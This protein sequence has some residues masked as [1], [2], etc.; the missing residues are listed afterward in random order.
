LTG[1]E[2]I[3]APIVIS[4]ADPRVCLRLLGADADAEWRRQIEAIPML[5]CTMKVSVALSELPNFA[6]RPGTNQDHH[7]G[8]INTPLSKSEWKAGYAAA[9]AGNLPDKLWTEL[10]FQ[11]AMDDSV[12]P[13]G[14]HVMSVFAQYVP[15][16]L[17][18]GGW[19]RRREEAGDLA[20]ASIARYCTNLPGAI[21]HREVMGPPDIERKVGLTG[22]HIFQGECLP[23][24]M[25]D[26][27]PAYRTPMSGVYLCGAGVHPGGSVIG[28]NGR[29]AAMAVLDD[30]GKARPVT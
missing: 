8:Q 12:A 30:M 20:I 24:Y 27:R 10:Y 11:S 26:R 4:N 1:G 19:E 13:P 9:R 3:A 16:D 29:N 6:A 14:C 21:V 18:E 22:G 17:N 5:G 25:W 23:D 2:R 28:V 7:R 15:Y